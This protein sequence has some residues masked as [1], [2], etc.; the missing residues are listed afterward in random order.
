ME[1]VGAR[2]EAGGQVV[3]QTECWR[4]GLMHRG[5]NCV[6]L[7]VAALICTHCQA[8]K[9]MVR[10]LHVN[11]GGCRWRFA[12]DPSFFDEAYKFR[13]SKHSKKTVM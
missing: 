8:R 10:L 13:Q 6:G 9:E 12:N 7:S 4:T 2:L 5:A 11:F 1:E 3:R